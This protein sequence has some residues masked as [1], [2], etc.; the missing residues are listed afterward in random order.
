MPEPAA[1][2]AGHRLRAAAEVLRPANCAI[3]FASV[4][5]G[6]WLGPHAISP[7]LLLAA[8]SASLIMA[9][10]NALNDLCDIEADRINKPGRPLPSGRLPVWAARLQA[11]VLAALGLALSLLLPHP[12]PS[13]AAIALVGL[14]GCRPP[15]DPWAGRSA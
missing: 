10:G 13:I 2:P 4:L 14:V 12:A 15:P 9:G 7:A 3:T 11:V 1:A 8:L 5:L 6:G